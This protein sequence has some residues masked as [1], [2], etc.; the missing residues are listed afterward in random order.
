MFLKWVQSKRRKTSLQRRSADN[1]A[2]F[3]VFLLLAI[4]W[5]RN[6]TKAGVVFTFETILL[7]YSCISLNIIGE[8]RELASDKRMRG[9]INQVP[10]A[11]AASVL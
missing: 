3:A 9:H 2:A 8:S 7:A 5:R 6:N 4:R 1:L 10:S 11:A